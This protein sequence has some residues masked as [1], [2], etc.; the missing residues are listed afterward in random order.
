MNPQELRRRALAHAV[1]AETS[2]EA[3]ADADHRSAQLHLLE[4]QA[5]AA[6]SSAF[7]ALVAAEVV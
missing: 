4:A 6:T 7:S 2:I 1:Q 5:H 3:S